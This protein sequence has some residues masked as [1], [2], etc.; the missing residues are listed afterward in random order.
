MRQAGQGLNPG[1][2]R[3]RLRTARRPRRRRAQVGGLFALCALATGSTAALLVVANAGVDLV[4]IKPQQAVPPRADGLPA[5]QAGS[6]TPSREP[7]FG[8]SEREARRPYVAER[9]RT[10]PPP[11]GTVPRSSSYLPS[12]RPLSAPSPTGGARET[13]VALPDQWAGPSDP[14][15]HSDPVEESP[16]ATP[17]PGESGAATSRSAPASPGEGSARPDD[18]ASDSAGRPAVGVVSVQPTPPTRSITAPPEPTP[19]ADVAAPG[20]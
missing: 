11:R 5:G 1:G 14:D 12:H 19:R 10:P 16:S 3:H 8:W 6:V 7:A 4:Q 18:A 20:G 9:R 15:D 13:D 2:A 17:T